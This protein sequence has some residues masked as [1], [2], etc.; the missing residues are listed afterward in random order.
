VIGTVRTALAERCRWSY[1][2][3]MARLLSSRQDTVSVSPSSGGTM[4]VVAWG[5]TG[6]GVI[7]LLGALALW[8]HYGTTVFFE[9]IAS[10]ISSCF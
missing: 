7:A 2:N 10:G 6:L 4:S 8:F 9:M 1:L 3:G 5:G